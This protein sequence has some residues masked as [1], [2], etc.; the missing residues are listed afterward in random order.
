M[1]ALQPT[2]RL[3]ALR[4][5][6]HAI[7]F[8]P[9]G[10]R[11]AYAGGDPLSGSRCVREVACWRPPDQLLWAHEDRGRRVQ[12]V[13]FSPDGRR[14]LCAEQGP[15]V[16]ELDAATGAVVRRTEAH[17]GNAVHGVAYAPDGA[18][19]ATASWD[20]TVKLWR[21]ADATL[22]ATLTGDED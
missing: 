6:G 1:I 10:D 3:A 12:E 7:A 17:P 13:A 2:H 15:H 14:L 22:L 8:S 11:L 18:T 4:N 20:T 9:R 19:F 16:T 5:G 21:A